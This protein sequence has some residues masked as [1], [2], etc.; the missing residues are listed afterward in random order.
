MG[1][2]SPEI[3]L[4]ADALQMANSLFYAVEADRSPSD[5]DQALI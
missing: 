3:S 4:A 5:A 1:K 2:N